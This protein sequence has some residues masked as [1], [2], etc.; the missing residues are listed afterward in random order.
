MTLKDVLREEA[1]RIY[2]VTEKLIRRVDAS[3]LGW[4]PASGR[5]WMTTAQLIMHCSNESCGRA[6]QAFITGDFGLPE[7]TK[8]EDLPP[9]QAMPPAEAMPAVSSVEQALQLLAAD[10][11]IAHRTLADCD[12]SLLL[13]QRSTAPWGGPG[14]SLFQHLLHMIDHLDQ[15]KGQLFYYLKL[16]GKDVNTSDLWGM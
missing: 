5:N 7:G 4:K 14:V 16:M 8:F 10:R 11:E 13:S 1:D 6:M 15:H 9:E 12:E 2:D 3:E